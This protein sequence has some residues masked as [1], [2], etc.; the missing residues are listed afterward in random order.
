MIVFD[1]VVHSHLYYFD[2]FEMKRYLTNDHDLDEIPTFFSQSNCI[3]T[4]VIIN[5]NECTKI[6]HWRMIFT[7]ETFDIHMHECVD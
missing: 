1:C 4:M 3:R 2:D 6:I 7:N 5:V